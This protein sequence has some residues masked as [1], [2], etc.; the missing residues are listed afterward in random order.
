MPRGLLGGL[1]QQQRLAHAW[2]PLH[3]HHPAKP[4]LSTPQ[5]VTEYLLLRLPFGY[6]L[7]AGRLHRR[8][9]FPQAFR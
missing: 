6:D 4:S 8:P 9:D 3:Q 7:L 2:L 1:A 5:Q